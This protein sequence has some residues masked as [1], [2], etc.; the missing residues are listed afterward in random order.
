MT[1]L[2]KMIHK[3]SVHEQYG[4]KWDRDGIKQS[5]AT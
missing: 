5:E 1:T 3:L 2:V 4:Q